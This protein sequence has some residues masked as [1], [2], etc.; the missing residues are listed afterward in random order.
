MFETGPLYLENLNATEPEVVNQG[1]TSSGKTYSI[2]QVLC[3]K[4]VSEPK[5]VIT[6]AGQDIP[7]LKKGALRDMERI[8]D[9]SDQLR[10]LVKG[11]NRSDR[12]YTFHSGSMMEF[13]SYADAQD[14]KSGKRHYL[15]V[16][17]ANGIAYPI[18][19]ELALRTTIQTFID[20]NPNAEFWVHEHILTKA[21]GEMRLIISDHRHNPFCPQSIKKKIEALKHQDPELF[22]VYG[23]GRTGKIEGLIFRNWFLCD[24]VPKGAKFIGYG[25]DFGFTNDPTALPGVWM[26]DGELWIK[27]LIYETGLTN[28]AICRKLEE[29]GVGRRDDIIADSSEPKSITEISNGGFRVDG[30]LKG[31]DSV[32]AS[33]DILKRYKMNITKDST[34]LRKEL[35]SY[36]W[37]TTKD[38]KTLNE[39]VDFMNHLI[40]ALRYVALNKL[41]TT[42][43]GKYVFS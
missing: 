43:K 33:I 27:E 32:K 4:A 12:V 25:L 35:S 10:K 20:Y 1:G 5:R 16:N 13:N 15:F 38:G 9:E 26:Q 30:A 40:D 11:Y 42:K 21:W 41:A 8:V 3:S 22:K 19:Q 37:K 24:D 28:P 14:A 39:P 31:P 18:Y 29:V 2:L 17:E 6:V 36:K 34:N 7:N 23:R